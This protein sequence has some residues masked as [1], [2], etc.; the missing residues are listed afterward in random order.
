MIMDWIDGY[1][2]ELMREDAIKDTVTG[3]AKAK[4]YNAP[5]MQGWVCPVCGR[6]ISPYISVC[7]CKGVEDWNITCRTE[8]R[9]N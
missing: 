1:A 7:P 4:S 9:R 8:E 6:G 3:T 5:A 2:A